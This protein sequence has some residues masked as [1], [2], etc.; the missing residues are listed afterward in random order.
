LV[1]FA[2]AGDALTLTVATSANVMTRD[3]RPCFGPGRGATAVAEPP[4]CGEAASAEVLARRERLADAGGIVAILRRAELNGAAPARDS[5]LFAELCDVTDEL[6]DAALAEGAPLR[7]HLAELLDV[8]EVADIL[9]E[10]AYHD[11]H[12]CVMSNCAKRDESWF[13]ERALLIHDKNLGR[14]VESWVVREGR[15]E[16]LELTREEVLDA[17]ARAGRASGALPMRADWAAF[18]AELRATGDAQRMRRG[19]LRLLFVDH[20]GRTFARAVARRR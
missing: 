11:L 12:R 16:W 6:F 1:T 8:P 7:A 5:R 10:R 18:V 4:G 19:D 9:I 20:V 2:P 15:A 13:R 3:S 14:R 17:E